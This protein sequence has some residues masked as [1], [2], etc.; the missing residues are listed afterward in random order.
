MQAMGRSGRFLPRGSG[1]GP[2]TAPPKTDDEYFPYLL[3][4]SH[5][6]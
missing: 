3:D 2:M 1:L 5:R 6:A 4:L